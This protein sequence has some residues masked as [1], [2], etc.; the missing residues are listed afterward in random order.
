VTSTTV[1]DY[2]DAFQR[3]AAS[4]LPAGHALIDHDGLLGFAGTRAWPDARLLVT[5]DKSLSLLHEMLPTVFAGTIK[6]LETAPGCRAL[7]DQT[8]SWNRESVTA[9]VCLDL[10]AVPDL[11]IPGRLTLHSVRRSPTDGTSGIAL[12]HAAAANLLAHA[13]ATTTAS[14][15][16]FMTY[17]RSLPDRV[18]LFA[19]VDESGVVQATSASEAAG[20]DARVFFVSTHPSCRGRGIGTAMTAAALHDAARFGSRQASL[21]S[22]HAGIGIYTRLTFEP[23]SAVTVYHR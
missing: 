18:R 20:A 22:T 23:V 12:T 17:L 14:L 21:E 11:P 6:V 15:N 19:A 4:L 3:H 7:L 2:T 5:D 16:Q 9:M 1:A 8:H 13:A 10:N